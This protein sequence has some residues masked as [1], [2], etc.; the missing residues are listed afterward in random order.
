MWSGRHEPCRGSTL[1]I[2]VEGRPHFFSDTASDLSQSVNDFKLTFSALLLWGCS[3]LVGR[4]LAYTVDTLYLVCSYRLQPVVNDSDLLS[5]LAM[6]LLARTH[7]LGGR[8]SSG[9]NN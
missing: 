4:A 9:H 1:L 7:F 2:A 3:R 6:C 8:A 5:G